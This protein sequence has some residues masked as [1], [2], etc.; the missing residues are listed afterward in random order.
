MSRP[1]MKPE[2]V[3][4][5]KSVSEPAYR[6]SVKLGDYL[7]A[8][9]PLKTIDNKDVIA[10]FKVMIAVVED[11]EESMKMDGPAARGEH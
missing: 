5:I 10:A 9:D 1:Q 2:T 6:L 7:M 3:A 8:L 11:A 4:F